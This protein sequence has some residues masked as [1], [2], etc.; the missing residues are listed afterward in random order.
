ML[1]SSSTEPKILKTVQ[2]TIK[3]H[4]MFAG[5]KKVVIGFSA[6]P[7]SVCLLDTL[8]ALYGDTVKI[9]L[10]YV[11]HGLRSQRILEAEENLTRRYALKYQLEFKII[12]V[13]IRKKKIGLEAASREARYRV[14][15]N[16]G[17]KIKAQ[18]IALGHNF[19]DVLE[20]FLMNLL[21]GSG[22]KGFSSIP[23]M[24]LPFV[25]PLID[26]KKSEIIEYLKTRKLTYA[27]DKTNIKLDYRRNLLR[28]KIIPQL[29]Q[30]NPGLYQTIKREI[31]IAHEDDAY[32]C[33]KA[34]QAYKRACV[35]EENHV[36][37]DL[38]RIL[39]YNPSIRNR[40]VMKAIADL[41]GDLA[42]YESKH[43][44]EI[45]GLK[46]KKSGKRVDLPKGLYA[47]REYDKICLGLARPKKS[48]GLRIGISD[49]R[50]VSN[51]IFVSTKTARV[52]DLKKLQPNQE[53]FDL[54]KL[55]PPLLIRNRRNGDHIETKIGK[56]RVKKLLNEMR[57][58]LHKR[59]EIMILCDQRGILW[60]PGLV[61]AFRAFVDKETKKFLVVNFENIN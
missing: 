27:L 15:L 52:F 6:G 50:S 33:A 35:K 38:S 42:G 43:F 18:R 41:R 31:Q 17:K 25:R 30:I 29:L 20:T 16:Y 48:K 56:K 28:H 57:V 1:M 26:L 8:N 22:A 9:H 60:I 4:K 32:F 2:N 58:P 34:A 53:V 61:R 10:V 51:R 3:T 23:A 12:K 55:K 13:K 40:V 44:A 36:L 47:Q 39:R 46:D 54:T 49:A 5:A 19:D 45:I 21:R 7:D 14:L 24:R 11:N 37:L 59:S